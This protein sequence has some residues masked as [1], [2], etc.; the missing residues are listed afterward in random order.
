[1]ASQPDIPLPKNTWVDVT[2]AFGS[3]AGDDLLVQNVGQIQ[4]RVENSL[5]EPST[6]D[7]GYSTSPGRSVQALTNPTDSVWA[8]A[9]GENSLIHV[10]ALLFPVLPGSSGG[11]I[12]SGD[13][14][15]KDVETT[16][17]N[18]TII[19]SGDA[20]FGQVMPV[21]RRTTSVTGVLDVDSIK[22]FDMTVV[23]PLDVTVTVTN[24]AVWEI[25]DLPIRV[26]FT[27]NEN[28]AV[29]GATEVP[30]ASIPTQATYAE[31][32]IDVD[33]GAG[34]EA[35]LRWVTDSGTPTDNN[36]IQENVGSTIKLLDRDEIDGFRALGIGEFGALDPLLTAN[37][38]IRYWN[39]APD[40]D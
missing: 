28:L 22:F 29:T 20:N 36:G 5:A 38:T 30:L 3:S 2:S 16:N 19:D 39:I 10:D 6:D 23:P 21:E 7:V 9:I 27:P 14:P 34:Q 11:A 40:E 15:L 32:Y 18:A 12:G 13:G 26:K 31:I 1:M 8:I 17:V 37:L 4:I 24:V 35:G 25:S 33:S